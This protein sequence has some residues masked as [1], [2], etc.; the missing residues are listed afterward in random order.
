MPTPRYKI[1]SDLQTHPFEERLSSVKRRLAPLLANQIREIV[2]A[3][4]E[5]AVVDSAPE[6][7]LDTNTIVR[8]KQKALEAV[9][10][11]EGELLSESSPLHMRNYG[12]SELETG[13]PQSEVRP[14]GVRIGLRCPAFEKSLRLLIGRKCVEILAPFSL[15][16]RLI[17][18]TR[19]AESFT[20]SRSSNATSE[21]A[22]YVGSFYW[23][24]RHLL[25]TRRRIASL[26]KK[27]RK[28]E[29]RIAKLQN[30]G[31]SGREDQEISRRRKVWRGL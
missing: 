24:L 8:V 28:L 11:L 13:V 14:E 20:A 29:D 25:I 10:G 18:S 7:I 4:V 30:R 9:T 27:K 15:A 12:D 2:L 5:E 16:P 1:K 19:D 26:L 3:T 6:K 31:L 23:K 22:E 21:S 17:N